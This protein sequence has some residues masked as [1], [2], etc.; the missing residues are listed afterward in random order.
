MAEL[1]LRDSVGII[2]AIAVILSAAETVDGL[3]QLLIVLVGAVIAL[4]WIG[5]FVLRGYLDVQQ[6]PSTN[7]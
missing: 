4:L 1:T 5:N 6:P 3:A 2:I 7:G